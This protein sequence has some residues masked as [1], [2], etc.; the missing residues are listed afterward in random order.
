MKRQKNS[1]GARASKNAIGARPGPKGPGNSAP[2][3]R[4]AAGSRPQL[5]D[6]PI[7]K[8]G[9]S[10]AVLDHNPSIDTRRL[11]HSA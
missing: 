11:V 7:F 1:K 10:H 6:V 4:S 9:C 5:Y 3:V 8:T 2:A